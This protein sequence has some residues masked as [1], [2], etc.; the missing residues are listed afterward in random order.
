MCTH[1]KQLGADI[2]WY[3]LVHL[4]DFSKDELYMDKKEFS[5]VKRII[6]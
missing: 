3:Q 5:E 6:I 1:A 2:I 4:E